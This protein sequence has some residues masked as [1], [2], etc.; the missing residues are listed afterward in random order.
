MNPLTV[1]FHSTNKF[2]KKNSENTTH[3]LLD[4]GILDIS[5]DYDLFQSLYA[6]YIKQKNCIVEKKTKFFKFFVD[7]D[8]LTENIIDECDYIKCIQDVLYEIYKIKDLKCIVTTAD[9]FLDVVKDNKKY[10]KQGFHFHWPE[11]VVNNETALDI[12]H[13]IV[14]SLVTVFGKIEYFYD[15]WEKIVDECVY[16][17]NGL[18]LIGSD[19]CHLAD[20]KKR[21]ENRVYILKSVFIH[22]LKN[23]EMFEYYSSNLLELVKDTSIRTNCDSITKY[24]NLNHY[25]EVTETNNSFSFFNVLQETDPVTIEIKKFF[26]NHSNGYCVEDIRSIKSSKDRPLFIIHTKSKYCQNKCDF[27]KSNRIYFKL[28]PSGLCQ[29]CL[30]QNNGIHGCCR[31]YQSSYVP[32]SQSL[33][34]V[35]KWKK[36]KN[37]EITTLK[38]FSINSLLESIENRITSKNSFSGPNSKKNCM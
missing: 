21:Y 38:N 35:L 31:D 7:F 1:W 16:K 18:R 6:K 34:S 5:N 29:R 15:S 8:L 33:L 11:L 13:N 22:T 4:G 25:E 30:S 12:R 10:Y 2:T 32:L 3:F 9:K 14:T 17:K 19:K 20:G 23:E 36:P 27:H 24:S 28:T 37:K 26:K